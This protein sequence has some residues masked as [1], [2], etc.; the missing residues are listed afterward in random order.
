MYSRN[1]FPYPLISRQTKKDRF[2]PIDR[3]IF[4]LIWGDRQAYLILCWRLVPLRLTRGPSAQK[5]EVILPSCK[6]NY[7]R[8]NRAVVLSKQ[9][10]RKMSDQIRKKSK[11]DNETIFY[12]KMGRGFFFWF[13]R[14]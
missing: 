4:V 1:Q 10:A 14:V 5:C 6:S 9:C 8:A 2:G 7:L 12:S 11:E 13:D 3:I